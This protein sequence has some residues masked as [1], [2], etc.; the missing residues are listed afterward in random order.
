[1]FAIVSNPFLRKQ[2]L[3]RRKFPLNF[4]RVLM[5]TLVLLNKIERPHPLPVFS[6]SD[7]L[8]QVDSA[9]PD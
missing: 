9:D 3:L 5:L 2:V 7:Y 8:I 4:E 6:Q 1:M